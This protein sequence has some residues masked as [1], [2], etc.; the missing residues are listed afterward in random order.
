[1]PDVQEVF[2]LATN[3]V[4]PDPDALERQVRLQRAEVRKSRV[5]AYVAVAAV[6]I[7]LSVA[8]VAIAHVVRR[9]DVTPQGTSPTPASLT[10]ETTLSGVTPQNA[11][12]V[13][14]RGA[15]TPFGINVPAHPNMPVQAYAPSVSADRSAIAF[16]DAPRELGYNQI[17]V[18][19]L[20]GTAA[21][22]VPTPGIIVDSVAISPDGLRIAFSGSKGGLDDIYVVNADGSDLQQL[23][24]DPATD[25]Y[26]Q[27]SPDGQTIV[28]DNAGSRELADP[29]FS[30]TAEIFTVPST[31]GPVTQLTHDHDYDAA[32]SFSPNG[33]SIVDESSQGLSIMRADGSD[34][35][36]LETSV[37]GFT[38]RFSPDGNTV[39]FSYFSDRWRPDVQFGGN[40]GPSSA[41][42]LLGTADVRT[43]R[44]TRLPNVAMATD[45]NTPQWIDSRH[46]FVMRVPAHAPTH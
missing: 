4:K 26:P 43:G 6:L 45:L 13:D 39:A 41:L 7:V 37:G 23:T 3:K 46:I 16:V 21:H 24:T 20:E 32:P 18:M 25:Q 40:Y 5:R 35:R 44:V 30:K 9:N 1:M 42:C 33:R 36:P 2:R 29:Q 17:A 34:L 38:P 12:I 14:P 31:G 15:L 10:F 28:F 22:F 27:W 19:T 11:T 8:V